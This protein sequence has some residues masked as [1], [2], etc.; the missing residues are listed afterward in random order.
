M[1]GWVI[2]I[3]LILVSVFGGGCISS[4]GPSHSTSSTFETALSTLHLTSE[5]QTPLVTPEIGTVG[6]NG[7]FS[8]NLTVPMN[9]LGEVEE[10]FEGTNATLYAFEARIISEKSNVSV[11]VYVLK[12]VP[13]FIP[14]KFNVT[15]NAHLINGTVFVPYTQGIPVSVEVGN[16]KTTSYL[17]VH[18]ENVVRATGALKKSELDNLNGSTILTVNGLRF[19]VQVSKPGS[20][21]LIVLHNGTEVSSGGLEVG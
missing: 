17:D 16:F 9:I 12:L 7:T 8:G 10:F 19:V 1:R 11:I 21:T 15:V 3:V 5:G 6:I 4:V 14:R 13:P 20:Y 2:I 18:P